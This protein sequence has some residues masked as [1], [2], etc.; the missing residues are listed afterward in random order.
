MV[1]STKV[2]N[3]VSSFFCGKLSFNFNCAFYN[4]DVSILR[5]TSDLKVEPLNF[6]S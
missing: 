4:E 2:E 1:G 6:T 3:L 5:M